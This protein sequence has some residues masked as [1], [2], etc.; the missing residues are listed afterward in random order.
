MAKKL[1][2]LAKK[3]NSR[4][5]YK[6]ITQP[7]S[8]VQGSLIRT[9]FLDAETAYDTS[10]AKKAQL[11]ADKVAAQSA[12]DDAIAAGDDLADDAT[13]N[14]ETIATNTA[15]IAEMEAEIESLKK[16]FKLFVLSG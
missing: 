8:P 1:T 5:S 4:V 2:R 6:I 12:L 9:L 15:T 11:E 10:A 7:S 16:K 3:P 14:E 13:K